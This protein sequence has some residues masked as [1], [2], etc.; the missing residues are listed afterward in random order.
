[1]IPTDAKIALLCHGFLGTRHGKLAEGMLRYGTHEIVAVVDRDNVGVST[2]ARFKITRDVPVVASVEHAADLGA[3]VLI[4]AIT[5]SGGR[6]PSD[7]D[8]EI[9]VG[10]QRGMSLVN[11]L[12]RPL[13]GDTA[14]TSQLHQG[15]F[16]LDVRQEPPNLGPGTGRAKELACRRILTVG[17]D[18]AIGKMTASLELDLEARKR[19]LRSRFAATGQVGICI[20]GDGVALDGVRVDFATGAVESM[21]LRLGADT[22]F[23]WVEGQGSV[24]HPG[25]TAWLGLMRGS[26]PTDMVLIHRAD[27]SEIVTPTGFPFPPLRE[28]IELYEAVARVNRGFTLPR[29]RGIAMNTAHIGSDEQARD[30][31]AQIEKET[32]LPTTD[33]VRFGAG[34]LLDAIVNAAQT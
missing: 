13:A 1:M 5:P 4:I 18:M 3:D 20:S 19:G 34:P 6:L 23:L 24:L 21:C 25:S 27:Q 15:R 8:T 9:N 26:Q 30:A 16:I 12:H 31:C 22:D 10:L 11:S 29:V 32:G 2:A 33:A 14:L 7:Y 28:T 17:T